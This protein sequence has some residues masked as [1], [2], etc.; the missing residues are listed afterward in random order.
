MLIL[1]DTVEPMIPSSLVG[2]NSVVLCCFFQL[3]LTENSP[4]PPE[5]RVATETSGVKLVSQITAS[6]RFQ[7]GVGPLL[8]LRSTRDNYSGI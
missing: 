6:K 3:S 8:D 7:N 5:K 2:M 4:L 1:E